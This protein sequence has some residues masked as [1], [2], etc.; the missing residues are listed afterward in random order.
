MSCGLSIRHP[1]SLDEWM[2]GVDD[3]LKPIA[4]AVSGSI[5]CPASIMEKNGFLN[6]R[7]G[8][9]ID[10]EARK[11]DKHTE[12]CCVVFAKE[13]WSIEWWSIAKTFCSSWLGSLT[14][15]KWSWK[16]QQSLCFTGGRSQKTK[17]STLRHRTAHVFVPHWRREYNLKAI[18]I[19]SFEG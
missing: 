9:G 13:I 5:Y 3:V 18:H 7:I 8:T 6:P 11:T 14:S 4:W 19:D 16:T 10:L 15:Q 1:W 12:T 2:D 17:P